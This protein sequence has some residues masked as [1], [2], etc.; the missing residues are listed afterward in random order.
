MRRTELTEAEAAAVEEV[1]VTHQSFIDSVARRFSPNPQDVPDI[2]QSVGIKLCQSFH[3][4][5]GEAHVRSW[6]Y[7]V[8][9]NAARDHHRAT[10][11]LDSVVNRVEQLDPQTEAVHDFDPVESGQRLAALG[12]AIDKLRPSHQRAILNELGPDHEPCERCC[13]HASKMRHRARNALR[14]HL[15]TDPRM[16]E[17]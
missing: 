6:L 5:R 7:R 12:D 13:K 17:L 2:V 11:R 8:T 1:F 4:F 16:D 14:R 3:G 9:M 10:V 15:A